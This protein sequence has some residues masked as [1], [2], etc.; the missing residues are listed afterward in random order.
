MTGAVFRAGRWVV[1]KA[2]FDL[3]SKKTEVDDGV[4]GRAKRSRC[5]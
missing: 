2:E 1:K 5:W 4:G 3:R